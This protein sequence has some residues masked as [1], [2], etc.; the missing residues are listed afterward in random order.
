M[1]QG[2]QVPF[3]I[4]RGTVGFLLRG[5]SRNGPHLTMTGEPRGFSRVV[6]GFLSY[7]VKFREPLVLPQG[8]PISIR[9]A[10]GSWGLL[11]SHCMANRP[12]LGLCLETP[13]SSSVVTGIS[14]LHSSFTLGVRPP[15]ECR[16]MPFQ[17]P[18]RKASPASV[19]PAPVPLGACGGGLRGVAGTRVPGSGLQSTTAGQ[20]DSRRACRHR[21]F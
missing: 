11:S 15:L 1:H 19:P 14:V 12:H 4:S 6:V 13:C 8:S 9:V 18:K 10:T 16:I 17:P 7:D 21:L 2:C 5:C 20:A 3:Q